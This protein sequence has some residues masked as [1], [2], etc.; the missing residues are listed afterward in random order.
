MTPDVQ[1]DNWWIIPATHNGV[2]AGPLKIDGVES[3]GTKN[4]AVPGSTQLYFK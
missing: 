2:G 3:G 4:L 1:V